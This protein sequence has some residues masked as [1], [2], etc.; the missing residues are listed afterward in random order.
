MNF[1]VVERYLRDEVGMFFR[2]MSSC[3]RFLD[4]TYMIHRC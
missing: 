2:A 1:S 4:L 3:G